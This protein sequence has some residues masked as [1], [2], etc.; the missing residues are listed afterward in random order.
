MAESLWPGLRLDLGQPSY[1]LKPACPAHFP[2]GGT[3][4]VSAK[5]SCNSPAGN[6]GHSPP[7]F[8]PLTACV[9][10]EPSTAWAALAEHNYCVLPL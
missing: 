7:G 1:L 9:L 2:P 8:N 10:G 5:G 6:G 4:P 3:L